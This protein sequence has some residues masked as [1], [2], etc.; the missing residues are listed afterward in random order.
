MK[1][2]MVV[3]KNWNM[4][5]VREDGSSGCDEKPAAAVDVLYEVMSDEVSGS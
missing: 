4:I 3:V 1:R 2:G 5:E